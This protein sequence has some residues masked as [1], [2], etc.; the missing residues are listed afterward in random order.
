MTAVS[1]TNLFSQARTNLKSVIS[2][3]LIDPT[4]GL[5][6][7]PRKWIYYL[8][9]DTKAREFGGYP[10][11]VL[12]SP[13]MKDEAL[14][15]TRNYSIDTLRFLVTIYCKYSASDAENPNATAQLETLSNRLLDAIRKSTSE[16]TFDTGN[17]FNVKIE[18][19]PIAD[20]DIDNQR[21][22]SRG[23]IISFD[24]YVNL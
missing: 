13:D 20:E 22:I 11:I 6:S 17:M 14:V 4:N 1:A 8:F 16:T 24:A 21:V 10:F 3:T 19:S 5:T 2:S 9:P 7:S 23:F 12:E 18:G 15:L